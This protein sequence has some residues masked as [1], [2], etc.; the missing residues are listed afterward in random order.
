MGDALKLIAL[1]LLLCAFSAPRAFAQMT[2]DGF[3][4]TSDGV[5]IHYLD[6][7]S[8]RP[9]V[10]VPGWMMPAWIWQK[11]ING[12]SKRFRVI[13]VDPRSQGESDKPSSGHL[14]ESRARDYNEL[15]HKLN[16]KKPVL[17]G[18]SMGCGELLSYVEQFG[19][20]NVS[21]LVLVDGL[22]PARQNPG[23]TA[24]LAEWTDLL[25]RDRPKESKVIAQAMFKKPQPEAYVDKLN[26]AM[27]RVPTDTVVALIYDMVSVPDYP[28]AFARID[29]P[30]LFAYEPAMQPNADFLRE[31]LG[32]KVRLV[33]FDGDGHALFV[34]DPEKFN[35]M[36]EEF[37]DHLPK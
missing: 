28:K 4:R 14:P 9:I 34:D 35:H 5:R 36:I 10:F 37:V 18:W 27:L 20:G 1:I 13:A 26:Q 31:R 19:E 3:I 7:G 15:I 32:D 6:T 12:L 33:R 11:Q 22:L 30:T 17:V 29:R 2:K 8:G 16:L 23:L 24:A 21:G 25:Q